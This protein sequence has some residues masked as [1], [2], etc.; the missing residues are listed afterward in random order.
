VRVNFWASTNSQLQLGNFKVGTSSLMKTT[1][2][3][4]E[5]AIAHLL[6]LTLTL[7]LPRMIIPSFESSSMESMFLLILCKFPSAPPTYR[8]LSFRLRSQLAPRLSLDA[9]GCLG[10]LSL[11]P[12]P[13]SD[14]ME[15]RYR[16]VN[17]LDQ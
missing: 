2:K 4:S 6:M 10:L 15:V 9:S 1:S 12:L 7:P 8:A 3:H 5:P 11:Q 14:H 13:P 16:K 17:I